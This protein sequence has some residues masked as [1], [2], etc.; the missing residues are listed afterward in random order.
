MTEVVSLSEERE[1]SITRVNELHA[2]FQAVNKEHKRE[3]LF[4]PKRRDL[5][6]QS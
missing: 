6:T 1:R 5:N 4:L 3:D 2:I